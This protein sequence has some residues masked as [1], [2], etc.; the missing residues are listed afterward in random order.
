M[1]V[2]LSRTT[3]DPTPSDVFDPYRDIINSVE[4][5]FGRD[6]S[7]YEADTVI[8]LLRSALDSL[9]SGTTLS[10]ILAGEK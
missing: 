7:R 9:A 4:L 10:R 3:P 5:R 6:V 1:C 8:P 2:K